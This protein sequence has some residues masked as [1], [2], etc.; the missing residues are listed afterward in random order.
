MA[1]ER[2]TT[3]PNRANAKKKHKGKSSHAMKPH[4][5][6]WDHRWSEKERA[7]RKHG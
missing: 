2:T 1:D 3:H 7:R 5:D 6:G 4:K